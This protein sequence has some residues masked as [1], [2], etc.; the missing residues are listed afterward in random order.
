MAVAQEPHATVAE[1]RF[2]G[3]VAT[4]ICKLRWIGLEEEARTLQAAIS[5]LPPEK[6]GTVLAGPFST[7]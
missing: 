1:Q 3:D 4:L 7:D 6:R 2:S 5:T